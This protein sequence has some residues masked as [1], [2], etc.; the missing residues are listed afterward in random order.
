VIFLAEKISKGSIVVRAAKPAEIEKIREMHHKKE[1]EKTAT[2]STALKIEKVFVALHEGKIVGFCQCGQIEGMQ[3]GTILNI[4][5]TKGFKTKGIG[6][7]LVG[8]AHSFF[9]GKGL[10][11]SALITKKPVSPFFEKAGYKPKPTG[12]KWVDMTRLANRRRNK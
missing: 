7:R 10:A 5:V 11:F 2:I 3:R 1:L 6:H 12:G 9:L 4:A 8:K